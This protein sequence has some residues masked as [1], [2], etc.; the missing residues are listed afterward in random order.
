[1]ITY[2]S[3]GDFDDL[4]NSGHV[5]FNVPL[6]SGTGTITMQKEGAT[7]EEVDFYMRSSYI[8]LDNRPS[9]DPDATYTFVVK[10][11]QAEDGTAIPEATYEIATPHRSIIVD[12]QL[13]SGQIDTQYLN[14]QV[15]RGADR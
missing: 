12:N 6:K 5:G 8:Y 1:M 11:F 10:N 13:Y 9:L 14:N 7:A 3:L 4:Q 15:R 2:S